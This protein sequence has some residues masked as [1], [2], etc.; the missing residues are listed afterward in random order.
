MSD[1]YVIAVTPATMQN[2]DQARDAQDGA[3]PEPLFSNAALPCGRCGRPTG[4]IRELSNAALVCP[5]C[6]GRPSPNPNRRP[7]IYLTHN[8]AHS[9]IPEN[10]E[11]SRL[12]AP[13]TAAAIH[14]VL[15][16]I[17]DNDPKAALTPEQAAEVVAEIQAWLENQDQEFND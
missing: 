2:L 11:L 8:P 16:M 12:L 10:P 1:R 6:P 5:P 9:D 7:N 3:D 13:Q 4:R 14:S 15:E 17:E